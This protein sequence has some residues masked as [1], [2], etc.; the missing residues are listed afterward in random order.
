MIEM[1][2]HVRLNIGEGS[3]LRCQGWFP[4]YVRV[5]CVPHTIRSTLIE[6]C[7]KYDKLT[8]SVDAIAI[9]EI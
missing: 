8:S 1:D 5:V 2:L 4:H 9:S 3:H 7:K 6:K